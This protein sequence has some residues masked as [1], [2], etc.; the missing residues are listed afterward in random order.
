M[1]DYPNEDSQPFVL[2]EPND[3][4]IRDQFAALAMS[5]MIG[6]GYS[7]VIDKEFPEQIAKR[8]YEIADAMMRV[9]ANRKKN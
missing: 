6:G 1:T 3:D 2:L 5:G 9:R 4:D 8:S 7:T